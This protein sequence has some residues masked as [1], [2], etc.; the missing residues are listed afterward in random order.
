MAKTINDKLANLIILMQ[1]NA[2]GEQKVTK[3]DVEAMVAALDEIDQDFNLLVRNLIELLGEDPTVTDVIKRLE[4]PVAYLAKTRD[5][6]HST[7]EDVEATP[8]DLIN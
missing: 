3:H 2:E 8:E 5:Q 7:L 6:I 4:A 1:K